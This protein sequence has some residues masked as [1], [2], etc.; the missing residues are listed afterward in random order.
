MP[1]VPITNEVFMENVTYKALLYLLAIIGAFGLLN[2]IWFAGRRLYRG[3]K[4]KAVAEEYRT[5]VAECRWL[6][7]LNSP[8]K[9][10]FARDTELVCALFGG[11][12]KSFSRKLDT[13]NYD[14]NVQYIFGPGAIFVKSRA[15]EK[16]GGAPADCVM[17]WHLMVFDYPKD[18]AIKISL[19]NVFSEK[20]IARFEELKVK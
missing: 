14:V 19:D 6:R 16:M 11:D 15:M 17:C 10:M 5:S 1:S 7:E 13:P 20:Y 8:L 18:D 2:F 9:E 3:L 12:I 4:Q